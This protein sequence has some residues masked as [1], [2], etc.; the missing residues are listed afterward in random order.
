M[1]IGETT[2]IGKNV[3]M[4]QGVTLGAL[5]TKDSQKLRYIKR[6][7]TVEDDV[8]IYTGAT[9]LGGD[10]VIGKGTDNT[11]ICSCKTIYLGFINCGI[12]K[13]G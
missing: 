8:T 7:P 12:F 9:I 6:H 5:S 10:T 4:C 2:V 13:T 1:V 3:K 11:S